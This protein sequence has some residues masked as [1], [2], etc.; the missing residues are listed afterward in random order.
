[1]AASAVCLCCAQRGRRDGGMQGS[2]GHC[3]LAPLDF[4]MAFTRSSFCVATAAAEA[5]GAAMPAGNANAA[6][7]E[8][9]LKAD[10]DKWRYADEQSP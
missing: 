5:A 8:A 4:D 3:F 7:D 10:E 1:V 6:D 2:A 9:L